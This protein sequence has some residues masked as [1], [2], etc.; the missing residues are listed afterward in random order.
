MQWSLCK[1]SNA[2]PLSNRFI[3]TPPSSTTT[4]LND[5]PELKMG[6]LGSLELFGPFQGADCPVNALAFSHDSALLAAGFDNSYIRIWDLIGSKDPRDIRSRVI[7]GFGGPISAMAT[8]SRDGGLLASCPLSKP[9]IRIYRFKE[10]TQATHMDLYPDADLVPFTS[11]SFSPDG[12]YLVA[13]DSEGRITYWNVETRRWLGMLE[14]D[15]PCQAIV[16]SP[17]SQTIISISHTRLCLWNAKTKTKLEDYGIPPSAGPMTLASTGD[18]FVTV[19]WKDAQ[20]FITCFNQTGVPLLNIRSNTVKAL[21]LSPARN[22]LHGHMNVSLANNML[23]SI[24]EYGHIAVHNINTGDI[25]ESEALVNDPK[26]LAFSPDGRFLAS[27]SLD[28]KVWLWNTL[29]LG[30]WGP[31]QPIYEMPG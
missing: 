20:C 9:I 11:L 26:L 27:S 29:P 5:G 8:S 10:S 12:I 25:Y 16:F 4:G 13:I 23:A 21:A 2:N 22:A 15:S 6:K 7:R 1:E 19:T 24:D 30:L 18:T 28:G 17:G 31:P 14:H 3:N